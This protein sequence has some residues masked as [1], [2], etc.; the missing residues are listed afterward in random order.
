MFACRAKVR[1]VLASWLVAALLSALTV[2]GLPATPASAAGSPDIA[3]TKTA[4]A[5]VLLGAQVT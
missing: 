2:V 3:M 5:T 1:A 4:P